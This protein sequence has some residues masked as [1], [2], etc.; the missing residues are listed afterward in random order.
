MSCRHFE[1]TGSM[2]I[3]GACIW[4]LAG[5]QTFDQTAF[6]DASGSGDT[7]YSGALG[8]QKE[9]APGWFLGFAAG[10]DSSR[11]VSDGG[12]F[13]AKG[14]P[15]SGGLSLK[16]EAGPWLLAAAVTGSCATFDTRRAAIIGQADRIAT[17]SQDLSG[18]DGRLGTAYTL[19]STAIICGPSSMWI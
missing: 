15:F 13:T 10:Y 18:F 14:D 4:A 5:G 3:Q 1:G 7:V 6:A 12:T 16:H 19:P 9:I 8:G 2:L 17:G 11:I